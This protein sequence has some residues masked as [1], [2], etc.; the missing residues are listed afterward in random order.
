MK[1]PERVYIVGF[2]GSGKT[3]A[4][5]KLA[6]LMGWTFT[7]LDK[8]IE[9]KTGMNIPD[10]FASHGEEYFRAVESDILKETVSL[11]RTI[12]STGG[13]APCYRDNMRFMLSAGLTVYLRLTPLQLCNRLIMSKTDRPLIKGLD[14]DELL[15]FIEIKLVQREKFYEMS[16]II[17]DGFDIDI[18]K[19]H[20]AIMSAL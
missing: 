5:K 13:G 9:Q 3:T 16:K 11:N 15:K 14:K 18:H 10:I 1:Y 6:A 7:D 2:M 17:T 20:N 8:S 12:I 4:G 19:I